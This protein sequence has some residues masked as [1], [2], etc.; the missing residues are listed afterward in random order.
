MKEM[1]LHGCQELMRRGV[2]AG[3]IWIGIGYSH[4]KHASTGGAVR[5]T[6]ATA[7]NSLIRPCALELYNRL[8][9]PEFAIRRLG[10]NFMDVVDESC[11]GYDL[12]TDW[13]AAEKEKAKEKAVLEIMKR[14][15]KNAA[16]RGTN[17]MEGATQRERNGMIGGHRAGY[18]D[19]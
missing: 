17:F 19:A 6:G 5:L 4:E 3:K 2:I 8:V 12:F 11:E 1:V 9:L 16:L 10:I 13:A 15:G 7:L 18:D 14:Y